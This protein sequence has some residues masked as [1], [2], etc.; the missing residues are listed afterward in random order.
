MAARLARSEQIG[1]A[2]SAQL[3]MLGTGA[4]LGAVMPAPWTLGMGAR[5]GSNMLLL[6]AL[7]PGGL[8]GRGD[9]DEPQIVAERRQCAVAHTCSTH[10]DLGSECRANGALHAQRFEVLLHLVVQVSHQTPAVGQLRDAF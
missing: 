3:G 2:A 5:F 7:Y 6:R 10:L 8:G 4:H 1:D 9:E